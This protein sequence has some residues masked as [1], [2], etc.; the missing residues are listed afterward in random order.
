MHGFLHLGVK[1]LHA[2]ADAVEAHVRECLQPP[3]VHRARVNFYGVFALR[4]KAEMAAQRRHQAAQLLIAQEGGRAAAEMKLRHRLPRAQVLHT[5]LH[6]AREQ[7]QIRLRLL[8]VARDDFVA[9][10]VVAKRLAK[11]NVYVKRKRLL[12]ALGA[13]LREGGEQVAFVESVAEAVGSGIRGVA[14]AGHVKAR[15]Q[16]RGYQWHGCGFLFLG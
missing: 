14:R 8:M 12:R 4:R 6:L 1:V 10:T 3:L 9:R 5:Q 7:L 15:E 2:E 16:L 13:A 11:R